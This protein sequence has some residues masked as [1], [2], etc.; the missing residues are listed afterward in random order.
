VES[1]IAELEA[2]NND[3]DNLLTSTNIASGSPG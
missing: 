1:K 2:T 3:L